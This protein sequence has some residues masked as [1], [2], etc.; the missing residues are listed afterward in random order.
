LTLPPDDHTHSE[1][2]WDAIQG[3]MEGSCARAVELGLPSI[4]FTEHVDLARWRVQPEIRPAMHQGEFGP[5]GE[6]IALRIGDDGC[7]DMPP[8]DVDG[9]LASIERC[10][11]RFPDLRILT[12]V[13]LGEPHWFAAQCESLLATGAFER[14]LGSLHSLK[15][16]G[17]TW[18]VNRLFRQLD[19]MSIT[20]DQIVRDYLINAI[21]LVESSGL[22]QVLAHVDYPARRYPAPDG[23]FDPTAF[24]DEYRALLRAL[25]RSGRALEV[26]TRIPLD[27]RIVRWWH[28]EGGDAVSFGSD[29]HLPAAVAT[30]FAEA[31]AMVEAQGFR[32]GAAPHDFWV[33]G[34]TR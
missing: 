7:Y 6:L 8:L 13:E 30:G 23:L 25:A 1:W 12:G 9:Y 11:A 32:P 19:G 24:E 21:D 27:A 5:V 31:A 18:E 14:I 34:L 28:E 20:P 26:N 33:R 4:A 17:A 29:A 3:S 10:R 22:F 15:V 2:S 16:D